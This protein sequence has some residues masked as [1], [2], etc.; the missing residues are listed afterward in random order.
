LREGVGK[1]A[2]TI[3]FYFLWEKGGLQKRLTTLQKM[4]KMAQLLAGDRQ[5]FLFLGVKRIFF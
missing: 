1:V 3:F 4:K 5:H 2:C